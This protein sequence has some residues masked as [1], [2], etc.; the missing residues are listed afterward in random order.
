ML[1]ETFLA[2]AP[3]TGNA[4]PDR[5]RDNEGPATRTDIPGPLVHL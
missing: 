2:E 3:F 5:L 4:L 1:I